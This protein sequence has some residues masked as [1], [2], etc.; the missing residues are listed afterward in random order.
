MQTSYTCIHLFSANLGGSACIAE[1]VSAGN[2]GGS[3]FR[4]PFG[5]ASAAGL[6]K[7]VALLPNYMQI[8]HKLVG[9]S[10]H[11]QCPCAL[12]PVFSMIVGLVR[13][14]YIEQGGA[15]RPATAQGKRLER[16]H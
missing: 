7:L 6:S 2:F 1:I 15:G 8:V 4:W 14:D 11:V 5:N 10:V 12:L 13:R 3:S 9:K 16:R